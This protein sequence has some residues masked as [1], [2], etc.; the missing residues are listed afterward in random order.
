VQHRRGER[1]GSD[2]EI[3]QDLGDRDRMGDVGLAALTGLTRVGLLGGGIGAFDEGEVAL[4]VVL[5][6]RL[7]QA[8]QCTRRLGAREQPRQDRAQRG[9]VGRLCVRHALFTSRSRW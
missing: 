9:G 6:H 1:L 8:I 5:P 4:G 3:G 7:H 2:A